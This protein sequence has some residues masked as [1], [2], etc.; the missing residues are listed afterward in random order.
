MQVADLNNPNDRKK[1]ILAAVLGL[2]AI[3]FLWWT[4]FGFGSSKSAT[5]PPRPTPQSVNTTTNALAGQVTTVQPRDPAPNAN[6]LAELMKPID[7]SVSIPSVPEPQRNIFAFYE[8]TPTP[9]KAVVTPTPTPTPTPP[10]LLAAVSPTN[11]YAKTAEFTLEASGDKFAPDMKVFMDGREMTT[12]YR[13]PQQL[14]A[15]I[16]ATMIANPGNRQ[17][18]VRTPDGRLY[19]NTLPFN[20]QA[21]PI[22]NYTFIGMFETVPRVGVAMVQDKGGTRDIL[23]VQRGDLLGGRFRVTSISEKELVLTDA[24]LK[25][26]HTL[27]MTEGDKSSNPMSRPTPAVA[28]EDDEP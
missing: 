8:P 3:L 5:T 14:S 15:A 11:V 27:P 25:I 23:S 2:I 4:F 1:L 26:K 6:D 18:L 24:N 10:V 17:V 16:P 22:P 9:V 19:S 21:P 7:G 13:S 28:S 12:K 20:I